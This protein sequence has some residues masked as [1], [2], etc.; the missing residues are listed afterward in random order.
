MMTLDTRTRSEHGLDPTGERE[1]GKLKVLEPCQT[2]KICLY[3]YPLD[4]CCCVPW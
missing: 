1:T 3:M 4:W 2:V